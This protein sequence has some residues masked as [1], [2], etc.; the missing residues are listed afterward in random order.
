MEMVSFS[1]YLW[2]DQEHTDHFELQEKLL[3]ARRPAFLGSLWN[4]IHHISKVHDLR[5][6][7]SSCI[8]AHYSH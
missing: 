4:A 3:S 2:H 1:T 6:F 7:N 8:Y 5:S